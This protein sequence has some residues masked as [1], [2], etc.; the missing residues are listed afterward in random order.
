[1]M[2]A[3]GHITCGRFVRNFIDHTALDGFRVAEH[4]AL[5]ETGDSI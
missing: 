1:M 5:D 2:N 3:E 4:T